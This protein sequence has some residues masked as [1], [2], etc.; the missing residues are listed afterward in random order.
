[1]LPVFWIDPSTLDEFPIKMP[2]ESLV[3][4]PLLVMLPDSAPPSSISMARSFELTEP[5]LGRVDG[6]LICEM[7]SFHDPIDVVI[8]IR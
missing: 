6:F 4:Y 5:A 7:K 1:M 3:S 8:K 2:S